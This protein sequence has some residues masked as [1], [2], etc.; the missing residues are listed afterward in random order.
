M[1]NKETSAFGGA[2]P[3]LSVGAPPP[4][5]DT[6]PVYADSMQPVIKKDSHPDV[7]INQEDIYLMGELEGNPNSPAIDEPQGAPNHDHE[8]GHM[9][10]I[11]HALL[12]FRKLSNA[13]FASLMVLGFITAVLSVLSFVEIVF[14]S[15]RISSIFKVLL[16]ILNL[17]FVIATDLPEQLDTVHFWS[18]YVFV[19]NVIISMVSLP[20]ICLTLEFVLMVVISLSAPVLKQANE[21]TQSTETT[22]TTTSA[23]ALS[24][25]LSGKNIL[26]ASFLLMN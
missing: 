6:S 5:S 8:T 21:T 2:L 23:P 3:V 10:A 14:K 22:T 11:A 16:F 24:F 19:K 13:A 1:T 20:F 25:Q 18:A 26:T 9:L 4:F 15:S 12:D 17:P 7:S